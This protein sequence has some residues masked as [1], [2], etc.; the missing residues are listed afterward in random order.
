MATP[1]DPFAQGE[2][3][4]HENYDDGILAGSLGG[5]TSFAQ[6]IAV[7]IGIENIKGGRSKNV[8]NFWQGSKLPG[9]IEPGYGGKVHLN[10]RNYAGGKNHDTAGVFVD[11]GV[12]DYPVVIAP[13][14]FISIENVPPLFSTLWDDI[15]VQRGPATGTRGNGAVES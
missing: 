15:V 14:N 8:V 4:V 7:G 2:Q 9:R 12:I 5:L 11:A 1:F 10:Y 6:G 13:T 3:G